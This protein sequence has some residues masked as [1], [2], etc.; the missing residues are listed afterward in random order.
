M[1]N[2]DVE[3]RDVGVVIRIVGAVPQVPERLL[4]AGDGLRLVPDGEESSPS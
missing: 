1:P 4:V 3:V 2:E